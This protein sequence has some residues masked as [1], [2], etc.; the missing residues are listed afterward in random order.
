M[1]SLSYARPMG[2]LCVCTMVIILV[3]GLWPFHAPKNDV[4]W[5]AKENGLRLGDHGTILSLSAFEVHGSNDN[6]SSSLE[7]WLEPARS[8]GRN[9]ILAFEG[10]GHAEALFLLQQNR[11]ALI[12]HRRNTDNEGN[13]RIAEFAIGGAF[14]EK[15]RLFV[16]ITLGPHKSSV[17]LDGVLVRTSEILGRP[18]GS[19][20][21]RLVLGNSLTTSDSWSGQISGLAIYEHE[22]T[23]ARVFEHYEE[24]TKNHRPMLTQDDQPAALYL[25]SEREGNIV[26]NQLG[27][28]TD[29]IIPV[30]YLVL[31]SAFLSL[32]WHGYHPTWSYWENVGINIVGFIPFGFFCWILLDRARDKKHSRSDHLAWVSHQP[33]Y[34]IAAGVPTCTGLWD[35]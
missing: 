18:P 34:R 10:S 16:T 35:E 14:P 4:T 15:K 31:Q 1:N 11:D 25:F 22:L 17:Y 19:L 21:G 32:P 26:H 8:K 27:P 2:A 13:C 24:W 3:A 9:T 12:V 30:R 5:L 20:T 28:S 6:S 23:A 33:H 7:I 29:L